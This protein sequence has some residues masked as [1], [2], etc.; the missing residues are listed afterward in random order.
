MP[1][2]PIRRIYRRTRRTIRHHWKGIAVTFNGNRIPRQLDFSKGV[3][4]PILLLQGFGST[5]RS[6]LVMEKRLRAQDRIVPIEVDGGV[7]EE[8][9]ASLVAVG[10]SLLVAGSSVFD[11]IDPEATT[12]KL[13]TLIRSGARP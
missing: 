3:H 6:L 2:S 11:G 10:A 4:R 1:I 9:A 13:H 7:G 5:R 8:N 12:R